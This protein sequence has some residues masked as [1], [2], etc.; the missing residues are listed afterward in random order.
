MLLCNAKVLPG[1][2]QVKCC[3]V[4]RVYGGHWWGQLWYGVVGLRGYWWGELWI[5][6]I[7][8]LLGYFRVAVIWRLTNPTWVPPGSCKMA[9]Y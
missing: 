8:I 3:V 2:W 4:S 7:L 1:Y 9:S 6:A 5:G